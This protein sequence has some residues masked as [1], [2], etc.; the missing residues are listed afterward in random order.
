MSFLYLLLIGRSLAETS[1]N[2]SE[3]SYL[4]RGKT[5]I[6]SGELNAAQNTLEQCIKI[7]KDQEQIDECQWELGWVHWKNG[8]WKAVVSTWEDLYSRQPD[9]DGLERYLNQSRDNLSLDALLLNSRDGA[10]PTFVSKAP[11]G[12]T[13]T[14]AAVGDMMIGTDF[15]AGKLPPQDGEGMFDGVVDALSADLT[16]GNLEGP[17]CDKGKT[18]KCK[19]GAAPGSCYAFRTPSNYIKHYVS[20]GFDMLSTANN[21]ASD[22]GQVCRLE[23]ER[24]LDEAKIAHSGRPGDIA[25]VNHND[26]VVSMIAFST[27]RSSHYINDHKQ[28]AELVSALASKSDIVIVSFH[29]GAEGKKALHVP[30][31]REK[32]YG[33]DRGHLR[34]FT[35]EMIDAGADLI[36]GHGPHVLRAIEIYNDR[37]IAYSLGNFATYGRFNLSGPN[38]LGVV[39]KA[40]LANDGSFV[41]GKLES[42]KQINRGIPVMDETQKSIDLIRMLSSEDFPES[43]VL[44]AKDGSI[45]KRN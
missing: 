1:V 28:A 39:L 21:H 44:V 8:D 3:K 2:S 15:P 33:E 36:L 19:P 32:F 20:A 41:S 14:I 42:T 18:T 6:Q 16:F 30:N 45:S 11:D 7:S 17:L 26:I 24:I 38:G 34:K 13:I 35:H 25:T 5:E 22:F 10:Q 37:L 40:T 23:T 31:G 43:G 9:K 4:D 27:S 29:G 12:A